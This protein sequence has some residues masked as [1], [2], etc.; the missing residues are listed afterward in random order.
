MNIT[1]YQIE[2]LNEIYKV[3]DNHENRQILVG[4]FVSY[5]NIS[6][7]TLTK[8]Y[9]HLFNKTISQHKLES[10]MNQAKTMIQNGI[11]I[12]TVALELGYSSTSSFCRR[13]KKTTQYSALHY[14]Q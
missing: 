7:S 12:K 11:Q 1:Q 2:I 10:V 4:D 6:E 14:K 3:V 8:F 13:F 9:K 5:Y